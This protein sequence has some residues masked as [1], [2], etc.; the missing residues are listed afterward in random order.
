MCVCVCVCVCVENTFARATEFSTVATDICGPS[1]RN[2]FT[3]PLWLL[4]FRKPTE[5]WCV[6]V[7][8]SSSVAKTTDLSAV[9][10]CNKWH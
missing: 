7:C 10:Q 8:V 3:S 1:I 9:D 5:P 6:C 2:L 4:T